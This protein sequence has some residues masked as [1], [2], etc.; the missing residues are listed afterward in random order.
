MLE[1]KSLDFEIT[2]FLREHSEKFPDVI[3]IILTDC[4][5]SAGNSSEG[6]LDGLYFGPPLK[7][8]ASYPLTSIR[9]VLWQVPFITALF[10]FL[11][12][13]DKFLHCTTS[14]S[15]CLSNNF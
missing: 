6:M 2:I 8:I 13:E 15:I 9:T 14:L 3:W 5:I 1:E 7:P 11:F 12:T 10:W 4:D